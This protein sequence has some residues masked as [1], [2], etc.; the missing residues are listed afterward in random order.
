ILMACLATISFVGV[1]ADS[2]E[3][4]VQGYDAECGLTACGYASAHVAEALDQTT[5]ASALDGVN[6]VS[7]CYAMSESGGGSLV[8]LLRD[9]SEA[10]SA[11]VTGH[12]S[13]P[14]SWGII[15]GNTACSVNVFTTFMRS[16]KT[17]AP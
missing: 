7:P 9:V 16:A 2:A 4:Q 17:D 5:C 3:A 10:G 12:I 1:F 14:C 8:P 15:D 13:R 6:D 11:E